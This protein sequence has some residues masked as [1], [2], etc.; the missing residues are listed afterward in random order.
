MTYYYGKETNS[1]GRNL[2]ASDD[3]SY[4]RGGY[5]KLNRN[6]ACAPF[7]DKPLAKV[8]FTS[9]E[10]CLSQ[11]GVTCAADTIDDQAFYWYDTPWDLNC[12]AGTDCD[13]GQFSPS[14]WTR[15]RLTDVSTQTLQ[16]DGSYHDVDSWKLDHRWGMADIDYQLELD[17]IQ[18]TG[19]SATTAI[20]LPKVGFV[21]TQLE[22]RLDKTGDGYAPFIKG[23]AVHRHRRV[24]RPDRRQLPAAACSWDALPTPETNTSRCF[25]TSAA[26]ATR[27]RTAVVQQIRHRLGD[28][29][30]PHRRS[31]RPGHHLPVPGR[32]RLRAG[33]TTH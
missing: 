30:G 11:T 8:N 26:T 28:G 21:Y 16:S 4:V 17:S 25:S 20:T 13:S 29:H 22:N 23:P 1:Y 3:T 9:A 14:F 2:T 27:P 5:L 31:R 18:H 32:S 24:R 12:K 33:T 15:K 19:S 10:R 6:T 7:Y